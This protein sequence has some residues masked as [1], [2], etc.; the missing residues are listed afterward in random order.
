MQPIILSDHVIPKAFASGPDVAIPVALLLDFHN[1]V[2]DGHPMR[3][4]LVDYLNAFAQVNEKAHWTRAVVRKEDGSLAFDEDL[5]DIAVYRGKQ[6][7]RMK[8][9]E[10]A[11]A[12]LREQLD[13]LGSFYET[14][15][16]LINQVTSIGQPLLAMPEPSNG[17]RHVRD[18]AEA[19]RVLVEDMHSGLANN[20]AGTTE[21]ALLK[22][23]EQEP[24]NDR[25]TGGT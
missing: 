16:Q 25:D 9:S 22:R 18:H 1:S 2:P 5:W 13:F 17:L 15:K 8:A 7:T 6:E 19:L 14:E 10:K 12:E 24:A 3:A 20:I 4:L 11:F 23:L 21:R